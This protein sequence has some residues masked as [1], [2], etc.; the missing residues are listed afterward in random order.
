MALAS[1][2]NEGLLRRT[3]DMAATEVRTQNAPFVINAAMAN[4]EHGDQ[5]WAWLKERWEEL[6]EKFPDN[7]HSRMV[8]SVSVLPS[9]VT[10]DVRSFLTAHPVKAGQRTVEQTLERMD[11]NVAFRRREGERLPRVF[12]D[13][14][15]RG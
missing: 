5:A 10:D 15:G 6:L 13:D 4:L 12:A 2:G 1:F 9:T 11:V 14:D 7:S 8:E 3:L